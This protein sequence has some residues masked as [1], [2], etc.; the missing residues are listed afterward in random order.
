M[1]KLQNILYLTIDD[2]YLSKD[3]ENVVVIKDSKV[4]KRFPIH[5]LDGIMCFNYTG[6]SP[7]LMKFAM[8][9]NLLISFFTP[10]GRFCGRVIGK[11]NGNVLLRRRQYQIADRDES[12]E[13]VQNIIYAKIFN[14]KKVLKR[15]IRDH[16]EKIDSEKLLSTIDFIDLALKNIWKTDSK[17][18][19]RAIEGNVANRYFACFDEMIVS[20]RDEFYFIDRNRR[21][22]ED[23]T[24]ALLSFLYS[25][26]T[27]EMQSALE[28]VGID[29]YVGFFHVDRPGRSSMA[30]D[31]IEEL[32]AYMCDRLVLTMINKNII[33]AKDFDK[34]ET[35]AVLLN[36]KGRAKVLENW[37]KRKQDEIKHPF[38]N[39][40]IK[41]GLI[42]HVQAML[43]NRY[44]RG[45][46]EAY[47]P[48]LMKG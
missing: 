27:Y 41:I 7:A 23:N 14:S 48:F 44:I 32:R 45:D 10:E 8:E 25:L 37:Q 2:A 46:L 39:E 31:M 35:G 29:S 1:K 20:Q 33:T 38:I 16:K 42:P 18:S 43:L 24:N 30:L 5:I 3:G 26:L 9:N 40:K 15:A 22:P 4:L 47:P 28:G 17:D 13:F 11:T 34:K 21:P 12:L 36:D 6:V 19:L